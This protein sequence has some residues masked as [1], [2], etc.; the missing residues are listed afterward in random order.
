MTTR[1]RSLFGALVGLAPILV[2]G[3]SS[4]DS[5]DTRGWTSQGVIETFAEDNVPAVYIAPLSKYESK[6][7]NDAS[8]FRASWFD[9]DSR[10]ILLYDGR[11]FVFDHLDPLRE[12]ESY[13]ST[14]GNRGDHSWVFTNEACGVLVQITGEMTA[15]W[16]HQYEGVVQDICRMNAPAPPFR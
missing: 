15:Y 7:T 4:N 10:S 16:A 1:L 11:V 2:A 8:S 13:Y 14:E 3:C 9:F 6:Y 5:I 12:I